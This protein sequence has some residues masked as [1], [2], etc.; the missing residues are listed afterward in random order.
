MSM[1]N[2]I[3]IIKEIKDHKTDINTNLKVE[4][5][6]LQVSDNSNQFMNKEKEVVLINKCC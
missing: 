3:I 5:K 6:K 1:E 2:Q 4:I